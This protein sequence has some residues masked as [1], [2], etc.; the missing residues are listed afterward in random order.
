MSKPIAEVIKEAFTV[1]NLLD[2]DYDVVIVKTVDDKKNRVQVVNVH[3]FQIP[4][5]KMVIEFQQEDNDFVV[6][7]FASYN[8][9]LQGKQFK[10]FFDICC[11]YEYIAFD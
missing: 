3:S 2:T 9:L 7:V 4:S 11:K 1:A 8:T 10:K 5:R 6:D